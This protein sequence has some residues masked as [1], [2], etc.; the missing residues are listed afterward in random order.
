[1][2]EKKNT[3]IYCETS[4]ILKNTVPSTKWGDRVFLVLS[5]R[6][7]DPHDDTRWF[8]MSEAVSVWGASVLVRLADGWASAGEP[9][10]AAH[11]DVEEMSHDYFR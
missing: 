9:L 7:S 5:S 2:H 8:F 6:W 1:M 10:T 4:I 3:I 11:D